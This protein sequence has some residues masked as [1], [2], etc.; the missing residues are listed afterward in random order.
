MKNSD[1][2]ESKAESVRYYFYL[3]IKYPYK[4][5]TKYSN[6]FLFKF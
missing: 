5:L 3:K 2:S 6:K 4:I 1:E